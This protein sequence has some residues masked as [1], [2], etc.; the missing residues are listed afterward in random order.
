MN[1]P[2]T[3]P[4]RN[5]PTFVMPG[6][7]VS[8]ELQAAVSIEERFVPGAAGDPD[9]RVLVYRRWDAV[10]PRPLVL[11]IH[12]GAFCF[13]SADTT[14]GADAAMAFDLDCVVVAVDYR[15]APVHRFPAAP[16]DCYAAL[17][18]AARQ[19][20]IDAGRI[21][22]SGASA[23]GAL[24][25]AVV[26]MAR[27]RGGP[28]IALQA[29][30]MPMLDDRLQGASVA[31]FRDASTV[32]PPGFNGQQAVDAWTHY[33]GDDADRA[34][35]PPYAAPARADDLTGLPRA[36]IRVNG[37]D[38][39]RDEGLDY[40]NRLLAAGVPVEIY[41]ASDLV[42]GIPPEGHRQ[43]I[44]SKLLLDAAIREAIAS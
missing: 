20:G 21:V 15:L 6:Q 25:A 16:E 40:A 7:E 1:E 23:G 29:L 31:Q 27:D 42:H 39:L 32:P 22:V 10:G 3:A 9:V 36:F 11:T 24:A 26:L 30:L 13:L 28:A 34:S 44:D 37:R 14:A 2:T 17:T 4:W 41:A 12:G 35:T 43:V 38:P 8:A 5:D 18:W 19:P 33:L